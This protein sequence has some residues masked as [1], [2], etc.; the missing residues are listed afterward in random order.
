VFG[1]AGPGQPLQLLLRRAAVGD[2]VYGVFVAQLVKTE[3]AG[4]GDLHAAGD[5]VGVGGEQPRHLR[6]RFQVAF[7]VGE[8][9]E[10][11]IVDGAMLADAGEHVL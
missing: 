1:G 9:P 11:G 6:R 8:Q 2:R 3:A 5:G 7:G 4:V 10:S